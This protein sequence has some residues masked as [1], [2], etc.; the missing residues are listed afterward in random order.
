MINLK[1]LASKIMM[2]L[3]DGP[4]KTEIFVFRWKKIY[5][6]DGKVEGVTI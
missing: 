3:N 5:V 2:S 4:V 1:K 6:V